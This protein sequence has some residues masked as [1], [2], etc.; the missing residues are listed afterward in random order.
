MLK[1][2]GELIAPNGV[3]LVGPLECL[4]FDY[5]ES[6]RYLGKEK[7]DKVDPF[8]FRMSSVDLREVQLLGTA[9]EQIT[10]VLECLKD[11]A[12][13]ELRHGMRT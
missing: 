9:A 13:E 8:A 4:G 7:A 10:G 6:R 11:D 12:S 1:I 3:M 5:Y 2:F